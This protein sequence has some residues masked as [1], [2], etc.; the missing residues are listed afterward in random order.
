MSASAAK[1]TRT[2]LTLLR[3]GVGKEEIELPEEAT[4]ADLLRVSAANLNTH[5]VLIDGKPLEELFAMRS[6]MIVSLAPRAK[7]PPAESQWP[8]S[9][10]AFRD[11][12]DFDEMMAAI[13]A[14][15]RAEIGGS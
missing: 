3:L 4:L 8:R 2:R 9:V 11:N 10:G 15:R 7:V 13:E 14:D 12:P 5:E 1:S 6:G